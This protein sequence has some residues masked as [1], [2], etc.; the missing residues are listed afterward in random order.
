[1]SLAL[2]KAAKLRPEIRLAQALSEFEASLVDD[3]KTVYRE[4]IQGLT[5]PGP[6]EVGRFTAEVDLN[7]QR[8]KSRQCI[9]PRLA[10]FLQAVQQFCIVVDIAVGGSQSQIGCAVWGVVKFSLQ[11]SQKYSPTYALAQSTALC[12]RCFP[13]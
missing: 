6:R 5:T 10:R 13:L 3:Q 1:M 9:G 4:S 11:V 8:R 7:A 12:A 2:A